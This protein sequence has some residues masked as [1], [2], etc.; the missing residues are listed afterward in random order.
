MKNCRHTYDPR[1]ENALGVWHNDPDFE[2]VIRDLIGTVRPARFIETGTHMGWTSRWIARNFPWLPVY[3]VEVD[4]NYYAVSWENLADCAQVACHIGA[5]PDFLRQLVPVVQADARPSLFWLDAHWWPPVPL[6]EECS[7]LA[8]LNRYICIIDDFECKDPD[9]GGDMFENGRCN[10]QYVAEAL[11][12]G[13]CYRPSYTPQ[14]GFKGYG[15]FMK[16]VDYVPPAEITK[17]DKL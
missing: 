11:Q 1:T 15:I 17:A 6:R 3:T 8:G 2:Y 12:N 4:P 14:P 5:S 10:L 16:N 9:F 13:R 7:I